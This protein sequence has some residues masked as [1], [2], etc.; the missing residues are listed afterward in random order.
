MGRRPH[1][2]GSAPR[3][4]NAFRHATA[5]TGLRCYCKYVRNITKLFPR[6]EIAPFWTAP[7]RTKSHQT[8]FR[9]Q[10]QAA[11]PASLTCLTLVYWA[12]QGLVRWGL[13]SKSTAGGCPHPPIGQKNWS[14]CR[15]CGG[16][17]SRCSRLMFI[18]LVCA[19][20]YRKLRDAPSSSLFA[21]CTRKI[22]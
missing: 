18:M 4:F 10:L 6:L 21:C 19:G 20:L 15:R 5:F 13:K 1:L 8:I 17:S 9:A 12:C 3:C 2:P 22:S 11:P 7:N 14:F 16:R